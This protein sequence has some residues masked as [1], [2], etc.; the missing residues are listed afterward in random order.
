MTRPRTYEPKG[1]YPPFDFDF[2][3]VLRA[4][5]EEIDELLRSL[6]PEPILETTLARILG[7]AGIVLAPAAARR[8][9]RRSFRESVCLCLSAACLAVAL[10]WPCL[11]SA[12]HD[13]DRRP[14]SCPGGTF[15]R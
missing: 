13:P 7:R 9:K 10:L 6:S 5:R 11:S 8:P 3:F 12:G 15:S 2:P 1:A 4:E 14:L